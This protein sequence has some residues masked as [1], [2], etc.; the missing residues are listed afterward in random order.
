MDWYLSLGLKNNWVEQLGRAALGTG[1]V[2]P[3]PKPT[4]LGDKDATSQVLLFRRVGAP[5]LCHGTAFYLVCDMGWPLQ[6]GYLPKAL[7]VMIVTKRSI[8]F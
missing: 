8:Y 2:E 6:S 4:R 1:L 5:R 3:V 7:A